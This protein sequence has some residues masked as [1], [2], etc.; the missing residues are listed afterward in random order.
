MRLTTELGF[1]GRVR[2]AVLGLKEL[3]HV[4][5]GVFTFIHVLV[6]ILK[7]YIYVEQINSFDVNW[8]TTSKTLSFEYPRMYMYVF[9]IITCIQLWRNGEQLLIL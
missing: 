7:L 8:Q 6:N 3:R 2:N 5:M 4:F 9:D 1:E